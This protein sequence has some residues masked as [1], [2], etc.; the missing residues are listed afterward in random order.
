M[1]D[2]AARTRSTSSDGSFGGAAYPAVLAAASSSES[3]TMVCSVPSDVAT[4]SLRYSGDGDM[5]RMGS[6]G[7]TVLQRTRGVTDTCRTTLR[8]PMDSQRTTPSSQPTTTR[9]RVNTMAYTT[10]PPA[11]SATCSD[12]PVFASNFTS[13]PAALAAKTLPASSHVWHVHSRC[14]LSDTP[15]API[16]PSDDELP[17]SLWDDR[18]FTSLDVEPPATTPAGAYTAATRESEYSSCSR[19]TVQNDSSDEPDVTN[20]SR[21]NG[22]K[23]SALQDATEASQPSRS[24]AEDTSQ[25]YRRLSVPEPWPRMRDASLRAPSK[26]NVKPRTPRA[27]ATDND[28]RPAHRDMA[29]TSYCSCAPPV[30]VATS[31]LRSMSNTVII[32]VGT[33]LPAT[34]RCLM[35]FVSTRTSNTHHREGRASTCGTAAATTPARPQQRTASLTRGA[36]YLD[37]A[38]HASAVIPLFDGQMYSFRAPCVDSSDTPVPEHS[39]MVRCTGNASQ[40]RGVATS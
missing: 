19:T 26:C 32:G 6:T 12:A 5:Y 36:P 39:A 16:K 14:G 38:L 37:A 1:E 17:G 7:V 35:P 10:T 27:H 29:T 15:V 20:W 3:S 40:H 34:T 2:D 18:A 11:G 13:S 33:P 9:S 25:R 28:A 22:L 4:K 23:E 8:S 31:S 21:L 24:F 30:S